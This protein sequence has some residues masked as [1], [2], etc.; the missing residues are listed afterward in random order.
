MTEIERRVIMRHI[1]GLICCVAVLGALL[2]L[3][4]SLSA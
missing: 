4:A 1:V 2:F 3:A